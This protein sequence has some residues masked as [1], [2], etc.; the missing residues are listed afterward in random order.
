MM[1]RI[2]PLSFLSLL[3]AAIP[4][5]GTQAQNSIGPL[6]A[7]P[8]MAAARAPIAV[9]P[10]PDLTLPPTP[11]IPDQG[12]IPAAPVTELPPARFPGPVTGPV[13]DRFPEDR[14]TLLYPAGAELL[15]SG[16]DAVLS[17]IVAR[18][19]SRP[20][21]RLELRAYASMPGNRP[22]DSRRMAL[23]RA[24][25]LR[26][27]LVQLGLDPLRLLVFAEGTPA[28]VDGAVAPAGASDRVDL[29]IRP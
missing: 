17:D 27:R 22:T 10:T 12:D 2:L 20:A 25:A 5:T 14:S 23:L 9:P 3:L 19:K 24:R 6:P 4:L 11:A 8:P 15:P 26:D 21:E 13:P 7:S 28:S 1:M 18:L 16:T 29:V